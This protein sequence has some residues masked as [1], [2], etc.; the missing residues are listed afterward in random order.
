MYKG[1]A[2]AAVIFVCAAIVYYFYSLKRENDRLKEE[3]DAL[4]NQYN[5]L[6]SEYV[7]HIKDIPEAIQEQILN[8]AD[9][10]EQENSDVAAE[11]RDVLNLYKDGHKEDCVV[12]LSKTIETILKLKIK[13]QD[14]NASVNKSFEKLI[15]SAKNLMLIGDRAFGICNFI[16]KIRNKAAHEINIGLNNNISSIAILGSIEVLDGLLS[17]DTSASLS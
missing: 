3:L 9:K 7:K 11:L 2:I 14:E 5:I 15:E 4:N 10:Y 17:N 6:F 13:N 16:R 12:R 1:L 8:L